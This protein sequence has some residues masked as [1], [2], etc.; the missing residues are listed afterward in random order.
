MA[1]HLPLNLLPALGRLT[2]LEFAVPSCSRFAC[3]RLPDG[4]GTALRQLRVA[5]LAATTTADRVAG[6]LP[7]PHHLE[8]LSLHNVR[9]CMVVFDALSQL[10]SL[11]A[12]GLR[13]MHGS[14]NAEQLWRG[15]LR[16]TQLLELEVLQMRLPEQLPPGGCW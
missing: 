1:Q 12:L 14:S 4:I 9:C 15:L 6:H 16:C 2:W 10:A 13:D 8:W 7:A 11:T 5:G 3:L